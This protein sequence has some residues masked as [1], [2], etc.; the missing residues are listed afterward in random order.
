MKQETKPIQIDSS[1]HAE[2]KQYCNERCLKLQKLVELLIKE[3]LKKDGSS[4]PAH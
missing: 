2:L 4:I 3:K 1:L